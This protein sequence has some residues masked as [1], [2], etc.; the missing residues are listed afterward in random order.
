MAG[1]ENHLDDLHRP[2]DGQELILNLRR[3]VLGVAVD[4][5]NLPLAVAQLARW[6][7]SR[8]ATYVC[9]RDANG[10]I[11][12]QDDPELS[13]IHAR[14]G[15]VTPDG[16]PLVW[17]LRWQGDKSVDRVYGPDLMTAVCE[18]M[19]LRAARHYFYGGGAGVAEKLATR[20]AERHRGLCV[21]GTATPPFRDLTPEEKTDVADLIKGADAQIVWVGLSTPKQERLMAEL[22]QLLPHAVL[23]GVGAAFDFHAGLKPQ[24]P[25]WMQR[26]GTEWM[27]RLA[28]EPRRLAGRYARTVPR[29]LWLAFAQWLG[30]RRY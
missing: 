23:I 6:V 21:A 25:L 8:K 19:N 10:V 17:M 24:A 28:T 1:P 30:L 26:S 5:I 11:L 9:F 27:F 2:A 22:T 16:M 14:A 15:M 12:C 4:A 3:A 18:D 20:L 13:A 29:F 7:N